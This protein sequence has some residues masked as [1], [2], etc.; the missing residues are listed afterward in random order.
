MD[1]KKRIGQFITTEMER[2]SSIKAQER[3]L[4]NHRERFDYTLKLCL[5]MKPSQES[6]ILDIGRSAFSNMLAKHYTSV[7]TLGFPL[8]EDQ[9]GHRENDAFQGIGHIVFDLND[10]KYVDKWPAPS[11]KFDLIIYAETIEHIHTS[12]EFSLLMLRSLLKEDGLLLI[13]TP[14]AASAHK[15]IRLLLGQNPYERI[16]FIAENP[17][18]FREYT[19]KELIQMCTSCNLTVHKARYKKLSRLNPFGSFRAL[20]FLPIKP[21]EYVTPFKDALFIIAQKKS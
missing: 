17:G 12:P 14:N 20:K 11:E 5:E 9:G 16:R 10:S 19:M 6:R 13:S 18:H 21:F 15:R 8:I 1:Y 2:T 3:Y 4:D 7:T